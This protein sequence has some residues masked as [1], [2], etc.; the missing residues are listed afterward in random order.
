MGRQLERRA[1]RSADGEAMCHAYVLRL[2]PAFCRAFWITWTRLN[3][4]CCEELLE[5]AEDGSVEVA[6]CAW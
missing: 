6:A 4:V 1:W 5:L 2:T 3:G